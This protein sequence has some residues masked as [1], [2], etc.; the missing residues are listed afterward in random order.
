MKNVYSP[1]VSTETK[2]YILIL[3]RNQIKRRKCN[4]KKGKDA[5]SKY[6]LKIKRLKLWHAF[7]KDKSK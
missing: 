1:L 7:E 3:N 6:V 4:T 2:F 5:I